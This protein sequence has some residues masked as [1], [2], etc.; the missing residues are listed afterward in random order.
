MQRV[1]ERKVWEL[2]S[3]ILSHPQRSAL[4]GSTNIL[5]LSRTVSDHIDQVVHRLNITQVNANADLGFH[6]VIV[7]RG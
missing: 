4:D 2:S 1:L 6:R 5:R 3:G 7:S